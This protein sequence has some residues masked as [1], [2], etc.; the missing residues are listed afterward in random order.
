MENQG[1]GSDEK[2]IS[3]CRSL[4]FFCILMLN[5]LN[6]CEKMWCELPVRNGA[7]A[8]W[9]LVGAKYLCAHH[10]QPDRQSLGDKNKRCFMIQELK[11]RSLTSG[12][13]CEGPIVFW[14][15]NESQPLLVR[16]S[17]APMIPCYSKASM[18]L[19]EFPEDVTPHLCREWGDLPLASWVDLEHSLTS[20][21]VQF[22]HP[23][24]PRSPWWHRQSRG[25]P[26]SADHKGSGLCIL[27]MLAMPALKHGRGLRTAG[28]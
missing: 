20:L 21:M 5:S 19:P 26:R 8:E 2:L 14:E 16:I 1:L 10:S 6:R 3:Y 22:L 23:H 17:K 18:D 9:S 24:K 27:W 7:T 4:D 25:H 15:H 12:C 13:D 11:F 28:Q